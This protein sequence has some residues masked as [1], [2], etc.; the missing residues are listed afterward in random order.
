VSE[1]GP[2]EYTGFD[3]SHGQESDQPGMGVDASA[4]GSSE[5]VLAELEAIEFLITPHVDAAMVRGGV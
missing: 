1:P 2:A 5:A 3:S 4:R